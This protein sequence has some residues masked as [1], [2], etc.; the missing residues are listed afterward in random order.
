MGVYG[1]FLPP[2]TGGV[3]RLATWLSQAQVLLLPQCDKTIEATVPDE[4]YSFIEAGRTLRAEIWRK[5]VLNKTLTGEK[6]KTCDVYA[7]YDPDF[8]QPWLLATP[9]ALK[10]ESVRAIYK[11][12]WPV[13][14]IPLS[15]KQMVG[16]HRQFV[17]NS[18]SIQRLPELAL[19]AGSILSF[20][21]ATIPAIPTGFWDRKPKRTP[22]RL[23]RTLMGKPFPKDAE[24]SGQLREKKSVTAHLPKGNLAR[25]LKNAKNTMFSA[26]LTL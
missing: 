26:P 2:Y 15:A 12:R 16:A 10:A 11:D 17:H 20:L 1:V 5:L 8:D 14:Q 22:G 6:N 23:R 7:I 24:I 9:V 18:E 4:T 3:E 25:Q 21:A 19:L 13:E